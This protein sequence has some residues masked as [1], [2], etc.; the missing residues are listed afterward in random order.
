VQAE[1]DNNNGYYELAPIKVQ[2]RG[3]INVRSEFEFLRKLE[4]RDIWYTLYAADGMVLNIFD[5]DDCVRVDGEFGVA[6]IGDLRFKFTPS[7]TSVAVQV[8]ETV[9]PYQGL[10]FSWKYETK[11]RVKPSAS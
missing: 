10:M 3:H 5:P 1:K 7:A 9:L 6:P 4:D 2:E 8:L 11:S